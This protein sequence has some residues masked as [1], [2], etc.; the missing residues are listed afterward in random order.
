MCIS[1]GVAV[2][3]VTAPAAN[4]KLDLH[5]MQWLSWKTGGDVLH[6]PDF[7]GATGYQ[8]LAT[9]IEHWAKKMQSSAYGCVFKLRCSKGLQSLSLVA[10]W[11]AASSSTDGSAFELPRLS[12]ETS[13][14]INI[15]PEID[16]DGEDDVARR[17]DER[18]RQL[19][20]QAAILYTNGEGDRLLRIH[21]TLIS[22]VFSVRAVYG[23][24][25]L[26]PMVAL[27]LKQ[28]ALV[29]L[30]RKKSAK[31]QPKDE[32]LEQCLRMF[33]TY[34]R[35]CY[36]SDIGAQC[37]VVSKTMSLLP[38]YI[39]AA[40]KLMYSFSLEKNEAC[41]DELFMNILRMPIH[42]ILVALYPRIHPLPVPSVTENAGADFAAGLCDTKNLETALATPCPALQE[43]IAKGASPAY[44]VANGFN[45]WL[46][47]TDAAA[48][49]E[50]PTLGTISKL[51]QKACEHMQEKMQTTIIQ[52]PLESC[53]QLIALRR[54]TGYTQYGAQ[55]SSLRMRVLMKC[56]TPTGWSSYKVILCRRLIAEA[57]G[58]TGLVR[59]AFGAPLHSIATAGGCM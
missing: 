25:S 24:V 58:M 52:W 2:S 47:R 11:P 56:P 30:D 21:T 29:A 16:H 28:A 32:L 23:S 55:H 14:A 8:N 50:E 57:Y 19:S 15:Q 1:G 49:L 9:H 4:V 18:K 33:T 20:V 45:A 40:R 37:L 59:R 39:L 38:L 35:H 13:F 46:V 5:T 53:M 17:R 27:M 42:S 22:V 26:A 36:T 51:A 43:G 44:I 10:P 54:A 3:A 48:S 6:L 34:R 7:V 41:R 12:P 31:V